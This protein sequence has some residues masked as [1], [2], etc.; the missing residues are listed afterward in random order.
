MDFIKKL[1]TKFWEDNKKQ[2][3]EALKAAGR[4]A[5]FFVLSWVIAYLGDLPTSQTTIIGLS[6]LSFVDKWLHENWKANDKTGIRGIS[7]F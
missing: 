5:V 2:I 4:Y 6:V 1:V 3:I 7:P